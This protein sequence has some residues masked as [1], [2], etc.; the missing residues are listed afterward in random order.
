MVI[1][2]CLTRLYG[3]NEIEVEGKWIKV[4]IISGDKKS[5]YN[6]KNKNE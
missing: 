1:F 5:F 4:L 6:Q 2:F 3:F